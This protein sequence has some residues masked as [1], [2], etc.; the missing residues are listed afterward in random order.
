MTTEFGKYLRKIRIENDENLKSMSGKLHVTAS[1]LSAVEKGKRNVPKN[2]VDEISKHYSLNAEQKEELQD[3]AFN[4]QITIKFELSDETP[5][6]KELI[7]VFAKNFRDLSD[8]D[9]VKI[10][11]ILKRQEKDQAVKQEEKYHDNTGYER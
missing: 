3:A 9:A 5:R 10:K 1:Y 11:N 6:N 7:L 8:E 4:S 2:W